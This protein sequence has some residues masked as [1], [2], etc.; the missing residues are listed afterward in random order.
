MPFALFPFS[1]QA[2]TAEIAIVAPEPEDPALRNTP[3][4]EEMEADFLERAQ[5]AIQHYSTPSGINH[6]LENEKSTLPIVMFNYL[7]GHR[8]HA[9]R[10]ME[11]LDGEQQHT[12]GIDL[13]WSFTIKGQMRKYFLFHDELSEAYRER[14]LRAGELWTREDPRPTM[15]LVHALRDPNPSVRAHAVRLLTAMR[16]QDPE[17]L[18]EK[19][20]NPAAK[21]A[22]LAYAESDMAGNI[23]GDDYEAW[24][25]WW[26]FYS[27]RGWQVYEEV[28]RV[29]NPNPHPTAGIGRGPVGAQWDPG[30][31][32]GWV[33][34]RNTDN[35][36]AMRETSVYLMAEASENE[37]VRLLY[38]QKIRRFVTDL[39]NVGMGEWDSETYIGHTTIPFVNLYDFAED[40]EVKGMAKA[41]LDWLTAS[42]AWKFYRDGFAPPSKR[43]YGGASLVWGSDITRLAGLWFGTV[44]EDPRPHYDDVHAITSTYRPPMAVWHLAN[45]NFDRPVEVLATKPVYQV[46]LPDNDQRPGYWETVYYGN[47]YYLGSTVLPG[48]DGDMSPFAL[49]AENKSRGVDY[50]LAAPGLQYN[51]KEGG[52]QIGQHHNLVIYLSRG[53]KD[54]SWQV[55]KIAEFES[56]NGIWF[57]KLESTW[58]AL[59]PIGLEDWA[60]GENPRNRR[61]NREFDTLRMAKAKDGAD[62]T[63]FA[64][65]TSDAG[66]QTYEAFKN[67]L[68]GSNPL[69][70][71]GETF[72]LTEPGGKVLEMTFNRQNDL[73]VVK[74]DGVLRD[75]EV[76]D[77]WKPSAPNGPI[78]SG[79][80]DGALTIRAGGWVFEAHI[81]DNGSYTWSEK[82]V[83]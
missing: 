9:I 2:E 60:E 54:F 1:L 10:E 50:V 76:F 38:K 47:H 35:L 58:L 72:T 45:K 44:N 11:G 81:D 49:L 71:D 6:T 14:F 51:R 83:E 36:R 17:E 32:G 37:D 30:I 67:S 42:F 80:K 4:T 73:P 46:F 23:P 13:Y 78:E 68:S 61:L 8:A 62:L 31:R 55:P 25:D 75:Y 16:S 18:A 34:A 39:Y 59:V 19:A 40:P 52:S 63:G 3:W 57:A 70:V 12:F 74:R 77:Q 56:E 24:K 79:W 5:H 41:A 69:Q 64:M 26:R 22:L 7:A 66:K 82:Q 48:G 53:N 28:E 29:A 33:D 43:D 21:A 65:I 20:T 27:D 15:E